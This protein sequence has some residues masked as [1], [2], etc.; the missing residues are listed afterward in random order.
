MSGKFC[1]DSWNRYVSATPIAKKT[2]PAPVTSEPKVVRNDRSIEWETVD[3]F[4]D[5]LA[6][7]PYQN[8]GGGPAGVVLDS[9]D[10]D[11]MMY[12]VS[13]THKLIIGATGSGKSRRIIFESIL[14]LRG[15]EDI[16][17]VIDPKGECYRYTSPLMRNNGFNI[18]IAD[19]RDTRGSAG[20]N[21]FSWIYEL[22]NEGTD[23]SRDRAFEL[24]CSIGASICPIIND[25]DIYW[26]AA[27]Q[28]G[29][30]GLGWEAL[31]NAER[32][33]EV[34][35]Y[36]IARLAN[37]I[38]GSD[39]AM[40]AFAMD[41]DGD[42]IQSMMLGPILVNA[43]NTRRCILS[44]MRQHLLPFVQS[45]SVISMLSRND[46]RF[47]DLLKGK[48][49]VY[50]VLPEEKDTMNPIVTSFIR[51]FYEYILDHAYSNGSG[52]LK[53]CVHMFC[54][55]FGN[56][57][58]IDGFA[59]MLTASRSRNVRFTI[60]VQALGQ[61][62]KVYG[63]DASTIKGNCLCWIFLSS[64]DLDT[65]E[66]VSALAGTDRNGRRLITPTELQRLD[67]TTGEALIL[68]DRK[69]P[70]ISHLSDISRFAVIPIQDVSI[71]REMKSSMEVQSHLET[72]SGI[73]TGRDKATLTDS[74]ISMLQSF[75][76][77]GGFCGSAE[78]LVDM[79]TIVVTTIR[80]QE[81]YDE[82]RR[83]GLFRNK[84]FGDD[85]RNLFRK[86]RMSFGYLRIVS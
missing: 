66:E 18:H 55:E 72:L 40:K 28:Y 52:R 12:E 17:V 62:R 11:G 37:R 86:I 56:L 33:E 38:F 76:D 3:S 19:L 50:I 79:I 51:L 25:K 60:A 70:F 81:C 7:Y 16:A 35:F 46:I 69:G 1:N 82:L 45:E 9:S 44:V 2:T 61:L 71:R 27:A 80:Y 10:P 48:T 84:L 14:S 42:P 54:D 22:Y 4:A 31:K 41:I 68:R 6:I 5:G 24:L 21:L 8:D 74:D 58:K 32:V 85:V 26:E 63:D 43:E 29:I 15:T 59:S 39:E 75:C 65:L 67:K 77:M 47:S 53:N 30:I 57:P 20:I 64:K 49:V 23:Y 78:E 36:E 34:S 13:D 73:L 83:K